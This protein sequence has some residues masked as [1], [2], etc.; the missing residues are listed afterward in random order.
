MICVGK[1]GY[2]ILRRQFAREIIE[3]VIRGVKTL[4]FENA[5][6]IGRKIVALFEGGEFDVCTVFFA[7]FNSVISQAPQRCASFRQTS[8]ARETRQAL[9][10]RLSTTTSRTPR[11][12]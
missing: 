7:R 1:K 8:A 10:R 4:G 5:D 11:K 2:D 12:C 9:R 3:L 6:A